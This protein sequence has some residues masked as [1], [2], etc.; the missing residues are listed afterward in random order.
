MARHGS[1]SSP[2]RRGSK[3]GERR[4]G[5]QVG[6]PNKITR[7]LREMIIGALEDVGGRAYLTSFEQAKASLKRPV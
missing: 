3:P 7:D 4:G 2:E 5:R 1:R 6:T